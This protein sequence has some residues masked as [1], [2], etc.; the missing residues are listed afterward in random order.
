MALPPFLSALE[1]YDPT[2]AQ[3]MERIV[4]LSLKES[5]LDE[6]TR[7]LIA[8]ALDAAFGA[9]QGVSSL[10]DQAR[11][12]GVSNQEIADTLRLVYFTSGNSV[13]HSSFAAFPKKD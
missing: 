13:L 8:L 5:S 11:K 4:D 6:K 2:F 3:A 1:N 12:M 10:A 9:T 7:T